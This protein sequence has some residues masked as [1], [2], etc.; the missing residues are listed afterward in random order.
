MATSLLLVKN[1]HQERVVFYWVSKLGKRVSPL[2]NTQELAEEW[3]KTFMFST[4]EGQE[5]R[6]TIIDRRKCFN[7]RTIMDQRTNIATDPV[8]RRITDHPLE[9]KFNLYDKKIKEFVTS[10]N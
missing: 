8:G 4:Y 7:T 6:R 1:L 10:I 2:K 9:V 5:R 3:W